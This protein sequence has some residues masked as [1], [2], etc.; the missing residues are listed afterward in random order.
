MIYATWHDAT[1]Y[2]K[3]AGKRLP[4]EAEWEFAARGGLVG[5]EFTWGDDE[6]V[7]RGYANF[8][9]T[10]GSGIMSFRSYVTG[11]RCVLR[12]PKLD[13]SAQFEGNYKR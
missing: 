8:R 12:V 2:A 6:A 13:P 7:A 11:F 3:W 5:K 10:G 1:A 9:G 4:T